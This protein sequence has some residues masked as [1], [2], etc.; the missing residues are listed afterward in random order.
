MAQRGPGLAYGLGAQTGPTSHDGC[1]WQPTAVQC[2]I[3]PAYGV[4]RVGDCAQHRPARIDTASTS[5]H[6]FF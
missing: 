2:G 5:V 4:G 1:Q 6:L 3:A